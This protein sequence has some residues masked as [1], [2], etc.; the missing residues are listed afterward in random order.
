MIF[1]MHLYVRGNVVNVRAFVSLFKLE[2]EPNEVHFVCVCKDVFHVNM[3][4]IVVNVNCGKSGILCECK[5]HI[6]EDDIFL[7]VQEL[8]M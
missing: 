1:E 7:Y 2:R 6:N 4:S 5:G 3:R 8:F